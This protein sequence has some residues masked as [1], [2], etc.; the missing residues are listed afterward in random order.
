MLL[1]PLCRRRS[2]QTRA[3]GVTPAGGTSGRR[4]TCSA[5]HSHRML[6][7]Q[8]LSERERK[9][10]ERKQPKT[11]WGQERLEQEESRRQREGSGDAGGGDCPWLVS[12]DSRSRAGE[13]QPRD[14]AQREPSSAGRKRHLTHSRLPVAPGLDFSR[15][16]ARHSKCRAHACTMESND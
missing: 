16:N 11:I 8:D 15:S 13:R 5:A 3:V 4:T 12:L 1:Q 10:Q 9:S 6:A 14:D 2:E 7:A